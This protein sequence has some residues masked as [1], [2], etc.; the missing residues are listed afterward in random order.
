MRGARQVLYRPS[1]GKR[2]SRSVSTPSGPPQVAASAGDTGSTWSTRMSK[3]YAI[4]WRTRGGPRRWLDELL[5][6]AGSGGQDARGL[7]L[8]GGG[9]RWRVYATRMGM[10]T[11]R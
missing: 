2:L 8:S 11:T 6:F 10:P 4:G 3:L 5:R 9:G 7:V 1:R